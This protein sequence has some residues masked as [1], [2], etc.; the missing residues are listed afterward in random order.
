MLVVIMVMLA[1]TA[2]GGDGDNGTGQPQPQLEN[3]VDTAREAGS[4]STLVTALEATG[5]DSTLSGS[6]NFTVFAPTDAAFAALPAG[7]LDSLL[8]PQNEQQL[9]DILSYHVVSGELRAAAVLGSSSL[10]SVFGQPLEVSAGNSPMIGN[11]SSMARIVTTDIEASNGVIH[12]IDAVLLPQDIVDIAAGNASFSTLVAALQAADLVDTLRGSGP[13]TVFAPTDDAF[14]ALPAGTLDSLL[15]PENKDLLV[16]ILTYHVAPGGFRS[17]VL[18]GQSQINMVN[19]D[20]AALSLS[21]NSLMID[22]ATVTSADI[23]A[24]NG[25]IHVIDQVILPPN[26]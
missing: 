19:G 10:E 21:G 25:V 26:Q 1:A 23:I 18:V 3:I 5:L 7:T 16:D 12:V 6:G 17:D 20:N 11:S 13:F 9:A 2:C 22:G 8:Q 15:L 14:A 24:S 4:F